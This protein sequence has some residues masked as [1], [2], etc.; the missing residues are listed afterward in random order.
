MFYDLNQCCCCIDPRKGIVLIALFQ[1]VVGLIP[2]IRLVTWNT[3]VI[4]IV[5]VA[6][7]KCLLYGSFTNHCTTIL[8]S[9]FLS[10]VAVVFYVVAVIIS[11]VVITGLDTNGP[12]FGEIA[13]KDIA[14]GIGMMILAVTNAYF[15][16]CIYRFKNKLKG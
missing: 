2:L 11:I 1:I 12:N 3:V 4:A 8:M 6:S 5:C 15:C 14:F 9:L 10:I 13:S 16:I 7:G